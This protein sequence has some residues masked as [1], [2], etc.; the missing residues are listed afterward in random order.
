MEG[1]AA[2]G[3]KG[4]QLTVTR[5]TND[6]WVVFTLDRA[7]VACAV[8]E[9]SGVSAPVA[10]AMLTRQYA[11]ARSTARDGVRLAVR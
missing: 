1:L 4:R 7:L 11:H 9:L 8:V 10:I 5:T 2:D 6:G 3:S